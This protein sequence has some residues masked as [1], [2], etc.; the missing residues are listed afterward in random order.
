MSQ[1]F[2]PLDEA[3]EQLGVAPDK[4]NALREANA[5]RAYKDGASWKFRSE[6]IDRLSEEGLPEIDAGS[7]IDMDFDLDSNLD[8][9]LDLG[10]LSFDDD[11]ANESPLTDPLSELKLA[12]TGDDDLILLEET[13]D[14][15][16]EG[17]DIAAVDELE[18]DLA[19]DGSDLSATEMSGIDLEPVASDEPSDT[20]ETESPETKSAM[21]GDDLELSLDESLDDDEESIL[22]SEPEFGDSDR[23]PST[24]IGRAEL[25][26]DKDDDSD[27]KLKEA[28]AGV[29]DVRLASEVDV[30]ELA[31]ASG[32]DDA[33]TSGFD[34]LD[35]LELDLEAESSRVLAPGDIAAAQKAA[36]AQRAPETSDLQL[37]SDSASDL[38][39]AATSDA[40][41]TGL[42]ALDIEGSGTGASH[43]DLDE[44]SDKKKNA[45]LTGL[46]AL[47][48]DDDE[49]DFVL[50]DG[51]DIT[52]SSADSGINLSPSDS[53]LALDDPS[54][55]GSAI[56]SSFDLGSAI[57]GSSIV[58]SQI[59]GSF[60]MG[61]SGAGLGDGGFELTPVNEN[62]AVEDEEDSSQVIALDAFEESQQADDLLGTD[63]GFAPAAMA[64]P[65]ALGAAAQ[66]QAEVP[67]GGGVVFFLST[68]VLLLALC[69]IMVFDIVRNMWSWEEPYALNSSLI[70]GLTGLFF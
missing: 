31:L 6:D 28:N 15:T 11:S 60:A 32:S 18:L 20:T 40:G 55:A 25:G 67:F 1:K 23:P 27:L 35:E 70:D 64:T 56:G 24:I 65:A 7:S 53:G 63:A 13:D 2:I 54:L 52:L 8:S 22:V 3:A 68:C 58:G 41:L 38:G 21:V 69:G 33:L 9:D 4:L 43:F 19:G 34:D 16:S 61:S 57:G 47:E 42:S 51:S 36:Q 26:L 14:Q 39:L 37:G 50:G 12:D 59:G 30:G 10:E 17:S 45:G 62:E 29:S 44:G 49:D 66:A 46:S 5:L 48:L